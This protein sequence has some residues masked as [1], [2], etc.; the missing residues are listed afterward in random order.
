M[1]SAVGA[2]RP[3]QAIRCSR[4]W[5]DGVESGGRAGDLDEDVGA[6]E[7]LPQVTALGHRRRGVVGELGGDLERHEP[8]APTGGVVRLAEEVGCVADVVDHERLVSRGRAVARPGVAR[9]RLGVVARARYGLVEDGR[10][11]GHAAQAVLCYQL[12]EGAV[13]QPGAPDL[14]EVNALAE[15]L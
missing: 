8:E 13:D 4:L 1:A 7:Q 6:V 10:V 12:L 5:S 11:G 2:S 15:L 14:V 9:D 3:P